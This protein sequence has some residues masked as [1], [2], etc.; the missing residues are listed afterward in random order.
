MALW[1][2][3]KARYP[4]PALIALTHPKDP[5]ATSIDDTFGELAADDTEADLEIYCGV[6]YDG[7]DARHKAVACQ[8]VILKLMQRSGQFKYTELEE[9]WEARLKA[10]GK[11]T[12]NNRVIPATNSTM[13]P[14]V[15]PNIP[16]PIYP[17]FDLSRWGAIIPGAQAPSDNPYPL[18]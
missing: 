6:E 12:G 16:S 9:K 2:D 4:S 15:D 18:P 11:V 10:L 3:V 8:G 17:D 7:L 13:T 14:T 5:T 1:D